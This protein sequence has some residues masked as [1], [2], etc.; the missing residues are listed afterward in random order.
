LGFRLCECDSNRSSSAGDWDWS[1]VSRFCH[2]QAARWAPSGTDPQ[3]VAQEA[4]MRAWRMRHQC[5]DPACPWPWLARICRREAARVAARRR[6]TPLADGYDPPV[7][8]AEETTVERLAVGAAVARLSG[9]DR[10]L[11]ELRYGG[12]QT[13][14]GIAAALAMPVG[15]VKVRLHRA[16]RQLREVL[17]DD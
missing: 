9:L 3:D 8:S 13:H 2:R 6:P 5:Q 14:S 1:A 7:P 12:D 17:A 10:A 15:T 11:I 16:R 4:V